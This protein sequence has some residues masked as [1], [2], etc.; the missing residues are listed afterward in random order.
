MRIQL[1]T[2]C[3]AA[4]A[5]AA[6][7]SRSSQR[8]SS[9]DRSP[10]AETHQAEQLALDTALDPAPDPT[11]ERQPASID[12]PME[13]PAPIKT[14]AASPR[15]T[16]TAT[17]P[18]ESSD[19]IRRT[20]I[21]EDALQILETSILSEYPV[22]RANALE[23]LHAVPT[24]LPPL[25][26]E[27]FI[28]SNPGV[29]FV[30]V[31]TVG[32]LQLSEFAH[33]AVHLVHDPDPRVRAAALYAQA[34]T[35]F[36]PDL[37]PIADLLFSEDHSVR[38]QAAF[39]LGELGNDSALPMLRAVAAQHATG[40]HIQS[41]I[42]RLQVAEAMVK[43]GDEAA[44]QTIHVALYPALRDEFEAAVLAAQILGEVEDRQA[45][46]QLVNV[47]EARVPTSSARESV[48]GADPDPTPYLY[49][50]ELRLAAATSLAKMGY[51]DGSYVADEYAADPDHLIRAQTAFLYAET[52][53]DEDLGR[54]AQL[55]KDPSPLVQTAAAAAILRYFQVQQK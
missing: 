3:L 16:P 19:A 6:C 7:A 27:A 40:T 23:A 20:L 28:D 18:L 42:F 26:R 25:L 9:I 8:L 48:R 36:S 12:L 17:E 37:S 1:L 50:K 11:R 15:R 14:I 34:R 43:L 46:Q 39:I 35:G 31:M 55:L 10:G 5:I 32:K 52:A 30:A 49:P 38:S 2:V 44:A 29:R 22:L 41:R 21:R 51:P 13:E 53:R 24:R 47:V 54:L 33:E 45:I 4:L